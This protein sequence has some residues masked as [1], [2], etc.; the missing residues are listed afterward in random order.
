MLPAD[1][2][3]GLSSSAAVRTDSGRQT[4]FCGSR[5][6]GFCDVGYGANAGFLRSKIRLAGKGSEGIYSHRPAAATLPVSAFLPLSLA[7][8]HSRF[9]ALADRI[10]QVLGQLQ[11]L[12]QVDKLFH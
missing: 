9:S 3:K 12:D 6:G 10:F 8:G 1:A 5:T 11:Y 4:L 2:G 7:V